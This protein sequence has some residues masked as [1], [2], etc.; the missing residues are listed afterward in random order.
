M[1]MVLTCT[2]QTW[3]L[4]DQGYWWPNTGKRICSWNPFLTSLINLHLLPL[5]QTLVS[6]SEHL[7]VLKVC[8]NAPL[9]QSKKYSELYRKHLHV[10]L[11]RFQYPNVTDIVFPTAWVDEVP[12]LTAAQVKDNYEKFILSLFNFTLYP[13]PVIM[14]SHQQRKL[15]CKWNSCSFETRNTFNSCTL[16][17]FIFI[18]AALGSG[19]FSPSGPLNYTYNSRGGSKLV[20]AKVPIR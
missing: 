18:F 2:T 12:F 14:G 8:G 20:T 9:S 1:M 11:F 16:M 4:T 10:F 17:M 13:G 5:L 6:I 19:I 15:S 3:C 7:F